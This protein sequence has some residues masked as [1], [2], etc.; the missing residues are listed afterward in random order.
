MKFTGKRYIYIVI[1]EFNEVRYSDLKRKKLV[2]GSILMGM[3]LSLSAC[4]SSDNIVTT[5]AGS[6]SESDF[7]KN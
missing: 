7:N 6:I 3:T 5:K 2:I 4:G 1:F